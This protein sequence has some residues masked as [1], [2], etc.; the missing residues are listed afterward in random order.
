MAKKRANGNGSHKPRELKPYKSYR[1]ASRDPEM[2]RLRDMA[3]DK[4]IK[5]SQLSKGSGVSIG[6]M[7]GWWNTKRK[8]R[9][10]RPQ[11][12]GLEAVGRAMG[13]MRVWVDIE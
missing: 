4:G 7:D 8:K 10:R 6:A 9:T 11:N 1:F 3:L 2:D 12:A 5:K 13:K